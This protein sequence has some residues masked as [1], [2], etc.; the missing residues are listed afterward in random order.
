MN[1]GASIT[2]DIQ[3][4]IRSILAKAYSLFGANLPST[5]IYL[6]TNLNKA[7]NGT[8]SVIVSSHLNNATMMGSVMNSQNDSWWAIWSG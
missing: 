4:F 5:A 2:A 1:N 6:T 8:W 7:Y 3:S